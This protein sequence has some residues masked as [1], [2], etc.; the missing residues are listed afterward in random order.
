MKP[1][2]KRPS[3]RRLGTLENN[4]LVFLGRTGNP[5]E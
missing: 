3:L 4:A 1:S 2:T 5:S